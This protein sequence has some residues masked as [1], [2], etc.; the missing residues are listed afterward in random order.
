MQGLR[1]PFAR[2]DVAYHHLAIAPSVR[3]LFRR[4]QTKQDEEK[5]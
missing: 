5:S 1:A 4:G 3:A 2:H